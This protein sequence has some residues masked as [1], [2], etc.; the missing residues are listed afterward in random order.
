MIGIRRRANEKRK[1]MCICSPFY[2]SPAS[3]GRK[4]QHGIRKYAKGAGVMQG[5]DLSGLSQADIHG[6]LKKAGV[7]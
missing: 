5:K 2:G 4:Q 6:W 7:I 1:E 3:G